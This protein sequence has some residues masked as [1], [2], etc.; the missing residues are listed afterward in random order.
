[1]PETRLTRIGTD[2]YQLVISPSIRSY[3]G[4]LPGET[5]THLAFVFRSSDSQREGKGEGGTDLFAEVNNGVFSMKVENPVSRYGFYLPND[6]IPIKI[7]TSERAQIDILLD[8]INVSS[9]PDTT[10]AGH[11]HYI[12]ADGAIHSLVFSAKSASDSLGAMHTYT[13]SPS[14]PLAALPPNLQDGINYSADATMATLVLTAPAKGNVFVLGDFNQWSL[15]KNFLMNQDGDKFWLTL[16]GLVP[17]KEYA[18]QYLIDGDLLVADP[19]TEKVSSFYDDREIIDNNRYPGLTEYPYN[20]TDQEVSILRTARDPYAWTSNSFIK[21]PIEDLVI[22]ELLIRDFTDD[23]SYRA[24]IDKLD[25]LDSLGINALELM[26]V[27]EFE[28]N[29][30]WGYNPAFMM[31]PDKYY[32]TEN[33]LKE[34]IDKAHQRGIAV[35][36]DIVLNHQFGRS[37]LVRMYSSGN[38]GPPT[39]QNPWFNVNAKH[40]YNVGYDMNHES[41]YTRSYVDRVVSYWINEYKIDGYRFDLSKGFT[42]KNTLGN[43]GAWGQYDATRIAL[44]KRMAD[45]IWQ[46]D[47]SAYVILEHFA[48]NS[49]ETVLADYGMLL[50]ANM[51]GT[52]RGTAKGGTNSLSWA[53]HASR[54]WKNPHA[55]AYMES[56][57]EERVAWDLEKKN[58]LISYDMKRLQQ[59]A[60]FFFL[61]P[62]PKMIWQFGEMGYD[63]EL[64]NDR[65]GIKPTHW[66][67]LDV[68]ERKGLFATYQALIHLKTETGYVDNQYF[69]WDPS[70]AVKWMNFN[71][72]EVK[73]CVVGNFTNAAKTASRH[74]LGAGMWYDYLTGDSILVD[75][76]QAEVEFGAGEFHVFTSQKISN[77][78]SLDIKSLITFVEGEQKPVVS[79]YPNPVS[80]MAGIQADARIEAIGVFDLSG[81]RLEAVSFHSDEEEKGGKV[82]L[83]AVP[84]G[85]YLL[86]VQ[87]TKGTSVHKIIRK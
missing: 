13:V 15:D 71:H 51:N 81:K 68:P 61:I 47:S 45:V 75:D 9:T 84:P 48:D 8:G 78:T 35:I 11:V 18:F 82:D 54:G 12:L 41:T 57:D 44:L 7:S 43:V 62:G 3:Y 36:L 22:Y 79:F 59:N 72:P 2:L 52:Y 25:Y 26:P 5:V 10:A 24:V 64:N 40:D 34:L 31:A 60:A 69:S 23:R 55:I 58:Q 14:S 16:T 74:L 76:P 53:Y 67:Y 80:G 32:G 73:I 77:Y 4:I 50:W 38:F 19:Y 33:D 27:M 42:Q 46:Q 83:S 56:H 20:F 65:L 86:H 17:K 37:P 63:E 21:P 29:L 6:S 66:E 70:A 39:V 1:T 49:E 85:I 28:G 87:T 30:S